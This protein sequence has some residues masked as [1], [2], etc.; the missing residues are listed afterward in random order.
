M[1]ATL[2]AALSIGKIIK[3]SIRENSV[4]NFMFTENWF[5]RSTTYLIFKGMNI[6]FYWWEH[7]LSILKNGSCECLCH[8]ILSQW[9]DQYQF[10]FLHE[11]PQNRFILVA[12]TWVFG[13]ELTKPLIVNNIDVPGMIIYEGAVIFVST[14]FNW[15]R[16]FKDF[17]NIQ[18]E[19]NL[20]VV[21]KG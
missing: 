3:F 20:F 14:T 19:C 21:K 8:L 2:L 12:N 5:Y 13:Y 7:D 11:V 1:K 9:I 17:I 16:V 10:V 18:M 6:F 4:F 15:I